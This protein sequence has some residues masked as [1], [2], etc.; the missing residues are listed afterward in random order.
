MFQ[1][2]HLVGAAFAVSV[3]SCSCFQ[4]VV[5]RQCV[6]PADC[7]PGWRCIEYQCLP[8]ATG[9]GAAAGGRAGG[10]G[11][12]FVTSGGF[13]TAGGSAIGGGF[14]TSGGFVISG[15]RGGGFVTGGGTPVGG[16]FV[17]GGGGACTGCVF[18][19]NCFDPTGTV[20]CG[21]NGSSCIECPSGETC[22]RGQCVFTSACDAMT[23]P[24]CCEQ[25]SCVPLAA[26]LNFACGRNGAT[27]SQCPPGTNCSAQGL[28][29]PGPACG[30]MSC[31]GCC[32]MGSCFATW[33]QG[34]QTCGSGGA[35]CRAC[36][37]GET[38]SNG[39]CVG[40]PPQCSLT[41]CPNGCCDN[42]RCIPDFAQNP[43]QCGTGGGRCNACPPNSV[44]N[45]GVC[46]TQLCNSQ[47]CSN[48]CCQG[49][50]CIPTQF[51]STGQ[52]GAFGQACGICLGGT[53]CTGGRCTS[54]ACNS[55]NCPNG[56]CS[57]SQCVPLAQQGQFQ[58]GIGGQACV[59]CPQPLTC[60]GGACAP[61]TCGPGT[62]N[63][64][65][66][67][68][69]CLPPLVQDSFRCGSNGAMCV[70]CPQG[71]TCSNGFCVGS[72][73]AGPSCSPVN[74]PGCCQNG[75]CRI[76]NTVSACGA[77][78]NQC[79]TCPAS[80]ACSNG[81]C[82]RPLDAGVL[83][84]TGSACTTSGQCQPSGSGLCLPWPGGYCAS[85]CT[86][87][88]ATCQAWTSCPGTCPGGATCVGAGSFS[89]PFCTA[90]C[91]APQNG[92][93]TCRAGYVCTA[94]GTSS[95]TGICRPSCT[96]NGFGCPGGGT[97]NAVT[98]YCQ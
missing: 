85:A 3:A 92:Q 26:Q 96:N 64:C 31:A 43:S 52:C 94:F 77:F 17:T 62:C 60:S 73:D 90:T 69:N 37:P 56:C 30:P 16:G 39:Q 57:G 13:V 40:G 47:N 81:A 33:L 84:P 83:L 68:N 5:E 50:S 86:N 23:C 24:G 55:L 49:N 54:S 21:S 78:G 51:Q 91:P 19:N 44:C 35:M 98:G 45:G 89:P 38:C 75:V 4:P 66:V 70:A 11:G 71:L 80:A 8:P 82:V 61:P 20:L 76:G 29:V 34:E 22:Q 36:N 53:T 42:G 72:V 14:V 74:C 65:C 93:S 28:C 6:A 27:C 95:S 41:T 7:A 63:G 46:T 18:N 1:L 32:I 15:G 9:G 79:Q 59:S 10:A 88:M 97:C 87:T 2:R 12:G 48:G 58:C 25:G 67:G